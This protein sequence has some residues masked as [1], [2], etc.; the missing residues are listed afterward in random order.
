MLRNQLLV[1]IRYLL[2]HKVYSAI[3]IFGLAVGLVASTVIFSWIRH[4]LSY[5]QH[6]KKLDRIYRVIRA[7][8]SETGHVIFGTGDV[9]RRIRRALGASTR[10]ILRLFTTKFVA[11]IVVA[12]LIAWPA[13]WIV[14]NAWL[15]RFAYHIDLGPATFA[16]AGLTVLIIASITMGIQAFRAAMAR[17][18]EA[19]RQA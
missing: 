3:N 15:D 5:D 7:D 12:N 10:N 4:E 2:S 19:L 11:L 9:G 18:V 17:P 1:A 6:H 8:R 16:V 14:M 13:A